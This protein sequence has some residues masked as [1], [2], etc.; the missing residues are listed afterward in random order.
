METTSLNNRSKLPLFFDHLICSLH[1]L[2]NLVSYLVHDDFLE[3]C[4]SNSGFGETSCFIMELWL[5][6][7]D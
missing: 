1:A 7:D 2:S 6:L 5:L 4:G 3:T